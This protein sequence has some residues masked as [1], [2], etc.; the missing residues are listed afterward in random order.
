MHRS[1]TATLDHLFGEQPGRIIKPHPNPP[2]PQCQP[3][4][5]GS[6]MSRGI[7]GKIFGVTGNSRAKTANPTPDQYFDHYEVSP[8]AAEQPTVF[9]AF[10]VFV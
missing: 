2:G 7:S 10:S 5:L 3:Q 6:S 4:L 9:Y 8:L 1:K